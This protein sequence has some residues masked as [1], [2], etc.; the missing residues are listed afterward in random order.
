M[1]LGLTLSA[2]LLGSETRGHELLWRAALTGLSIG[3]A[4]ALVL[5]WLLP[6]ATLWMSALWVGVVSLALVIAW[7]IT[8]RAG[9]DM[10]LK[11]SVFGSTGA[12]AFQL[13]TGLALSH[14]LRSFPTAK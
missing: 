8:R 12:W 3:L 1:A 6:Q 9:I 13:L 4:Q 10:D 11:W 14:F 7:S 5:H 2:A